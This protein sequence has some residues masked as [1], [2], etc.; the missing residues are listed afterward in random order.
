MRPVWYTHSLG[1][2]AAALQSPIV[3]YWSKLTDPS[4]NPF[5][6]LY[7]AN[8]FDLAVVIPY[9]TVLVILAAFGL[10]RYWLVYSYFK[11]RHNVPGQPPPVERWPLVTVQ[12]PI[13]NER[14]VI[15]RLIEAVARF[16]YPRELLDIQVLDDSTDET[17][18]VARAC[19]EKHHALGLPIRY[20]HRADR[21]GF[22][23]G[24]LLEGLKVSQA[25]F[26]AIFDAD[27]VPSPDFLRRTVPYFADEKIAMVQTRWTYLNRGYSALT[28]VESI[29][30]DGHFVIEHGA[31]SRNGVFFNFN[32]TA[33]IWR[34]AAID[35]AGGWEHDTLTEDTDLSYRAQ[36]RGWRFLYIPDIECASELPVEMNSFKSQQA[37]WAKGLMQTAIKILPRILRSNE[38]LGVKAEAT[39]HLTANVSYP[40]MVLFSALLLPAMIVRFYQGWFQMLLIDLPLFLAASCSVSGFYLA[41]QRALY[42]RKWYR[43]ILYIPFV[44]AVGIGLS[45]RNAKAVLEALFGIK[46]EFARTPKYSISGHSGTWRKKSYRNRAGWMPYLEVLLGFYFAA[47]V[48]YAIQNENYFTV[49]FLLLFVW[50]YLYT[51]LMSLGQTWFERMRLGNQ[52]AVEARPAAT[53]TPGF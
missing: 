15:E 34:R 50:G 33:G 28:N 38:P 52:P 3:R 53:D 17:C 29:L 44:M 47:T 37:R 19:V 24:A 49:P 45:V 32:G 42:P 10:H 11:N 4:R 18:E 6:G 46:S 20:L 41:A 21:T 22:K 16:D 23:A 36:L 25:E 13:Y 27:F 2:V 7:Q 5:R 40:L 39:F 26:V 43:S 8:T 9:F 35:D 48:V 1:L 14:Y 12:L 51:G 30:L 31:R